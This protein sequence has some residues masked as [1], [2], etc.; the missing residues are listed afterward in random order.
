M[1]NERFSDIERER[2]RPVA[3]ILTAPDQ[4]GTAYPVDIVEE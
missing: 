2:Q 4:D 3:T 1:G